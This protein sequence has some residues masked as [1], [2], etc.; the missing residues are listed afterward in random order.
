[1]F[2]PVVL[3]PVYNHEHAV[4]QVLAA[5]LAH[6]VPCLLVDDGSA[7]AC[8][9][10]L[11]ELAA[12]H[13]DRVE[14]LRLPTNQGKGGAIIAGARHARQ[15]GYSHVLQIDAD[16][17][18]DSAR[19]ADFL[20]LAEASPEALICGCPVYDESVPRARLVG[21]H[22][23]HIWV[24]INTLSF[25]VRDAMC[26]LRVYPLASLVPLVES[27][28]LGR[29]ME[30]DIEVLVRMVWRGVRIVNVPVRVTYPADG[31]SHFRIWRDNALISGMHARL[32]AGMLMRAPLLLARKVGWGTA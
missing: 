28:P 1:M 14:L 9:Q 27:V 29:R 31:V 24:W 6:P 32:F 16:G 21:R 17:Q 25:A 12:S 18:H 4:G 20:A 22:L 5:V 19:V 11:R 23:T 2:R 10:V 8:A 13:P 26:G 3:I 15:R 30:F 7:P